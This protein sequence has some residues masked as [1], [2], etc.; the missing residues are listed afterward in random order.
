MPNEWQNTQCPGDFG[1]CDQ[2]S[3][4]IDWYHGL[5]KAILKEI[6]KIE[7][8]KTQKQPVKKQV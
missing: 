5:D 6:S 3:P 7:K 2:W 4:H 1:G 8:S